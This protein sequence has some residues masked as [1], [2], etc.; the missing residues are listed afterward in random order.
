MT[1]APSA[2]HLPTTAGDVL[3]SSTVEARKLF[4]ELTSRNGWSASAK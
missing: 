1:V 3:K 2:I 4:N